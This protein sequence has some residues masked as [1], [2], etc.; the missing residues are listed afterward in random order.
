MLGAVKNLRKKVKAI[1]Q[2]KLIKDVFANDLLQAQ[3]VDLNQE[4]LYEKGIEAD[5]TPTGDY[6]FNTI[7]GTSK[8]EGKIEKGQRYDHI[9]GK[10]TGAS[11]ESM[12]VE[13]QPN[14]VVFKAKFPKAFRERFINLLGLTDES[15]REVRP[16]I[17]QRFLD[18]FK[19][20][21]YS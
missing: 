17:K 16:E 2:N 19:E 11:Y 21:I 12:R 9:T 3:M 6:A 1:N 13:A 14:Q 18:G 10:D 8:Y 5:G 4:Q 20:K 7:Y 15:Y